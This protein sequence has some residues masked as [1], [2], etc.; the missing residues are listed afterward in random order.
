MTTH[1][2]KSTHLVTINSISDEKYT[3]IYILGKMP[4]ATLNHWVRGSNPRAPTNH[5][6]LVEVPIVRVLKPRN[7]VLY[8][9]FLF[10]FSYKHQIIEHKNK[11]NLMFYTI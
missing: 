11:V 8:R 10:V 1:L 3:V 6:S 4:E 7:P 2:T 9:V 5:T